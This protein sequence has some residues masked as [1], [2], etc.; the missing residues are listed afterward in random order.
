MPKSA[1]ETY[2]ENK[3]LVVDERKD[4]QRRKI[5]AYMENSLTVN[6]DYLAVE[7]PN[8]AQQTRQI[9]RLTNQMVRVARW[10]R[11]DMLETND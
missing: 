5:L 4:I 10:M 1:L 6:R 3:G 11:N 8:P 9:M 2:L 7:N